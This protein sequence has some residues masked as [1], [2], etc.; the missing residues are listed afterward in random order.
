MNKLLFTTLFL[1]FCNDVYAC[2]QDQAF[3]KMMML[4]RAQQQIM[5]GAK[6]NQELLRQSAQLAMEISNVGK[7]LGEKKYT[8]A[9]KY[10]DEIALKYKI[11]FK[12]YS[13]D[14]LLM[15]DIKKMN[16]GKH[17]G[18][19]Q[20]QAKDKMMATLHDLEDKVA[21]GDVDPM[22]M[23]EYLDEA[24]SYNDFL[25]TNPNVFCLKMAELRAKYLKE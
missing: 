17:V 22:V 11:D 14:T 23:S 12:Q 16:S 4:G 20:L 21:L 2:T 8:E 13:K 10:Y 15:K 3:N 24:T 18:C 5:S 1:V 19:T 6:G 9:C 25:Y 7:V